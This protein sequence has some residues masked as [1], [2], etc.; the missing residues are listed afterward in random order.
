MNWF[1]RAARLR[2]RAAKLSATASGTVVVGEQR[3]P[4][5]R[6]LIG[7]LE[8]NGFGIILDASGREHP[9]T[10]NALHHY[11]GESAATMAARGVAVG[12]TVHFAWTGDKVTFIEWPKEFS[13]TASGGPS[14]PARPRPS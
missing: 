2:E 1:W 14:S 8:P 12:H 6:G 13:P 9:F 3:V 4:L 10:F 11:R 5:Y 7:R